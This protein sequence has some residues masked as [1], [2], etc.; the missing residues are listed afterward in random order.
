MAS[1]TLFLRADDGEHG[2]E[3]W[4]SDGTAAGT[5]LVKDILPGSNGSYAYP[6]S[7]TEVGGTLF[8]MAYDEQHGVELWKSDGTAEG[9]LL[10]RDIR[11]GSKSSAPPSLGIDCLLTDVD[12][13]AYFR[14]DDGEHG[15]ELWK[16]DGTAAGTVLVKDILPGSDGSYPWKLTAVEET[17]FFDVGGELW[18]S[19]GTEGGTVLVKDV[20]PQSLTDFDGRLF[21]TAADPQHGRELWTSDG[22]PAGTLLVSDI[23]AIGGSNPKNLSVVGGTLFFT[24][25]DGLNGRELWALPAA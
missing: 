8:F 22:T 23:S 3:L 5:V 17:L 2:S 1:G 6:G 13:I 4:K 20:E 18:K 16:S 11:P 14:V 15:F 9:T 10:V 25:D 12:G 21:F 7:L 24:A 19:D